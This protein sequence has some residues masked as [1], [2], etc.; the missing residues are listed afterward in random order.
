MLNKALCMCYQHLNLVWW[1]GSHE[2]IARIWTSCRTHSLWSRHSSSQAY[3]I[4]EIWNTWMWAC[5]VLQ[6]YHKE[7][8]L[9]KTFLTQPALALCRNI[10]I[11][12]CKMRAHMHVLTLTHGCTDSLCLY[13]HTH[14]YTCI[15]SH[16]HYLNT[17]APSSTCMHLKST[18]V[19]QCQLPTAQPILPLAHFTHVAIH[20]TSPPSPSLG[21]TLLFTLLR[22]M[23]RLKNIICSV[24]CTPQY[25]IFTVSCTFLYW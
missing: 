3:C 14:S 25:N 21:K 6:T 10:W 11:I 2:H 18:L 13:E 24:A 23:I 15:H 9:I 5:Y 4:G 17:R 12:W 1:Q 16:T 8:G 19:H 22:K 7:L 20:I